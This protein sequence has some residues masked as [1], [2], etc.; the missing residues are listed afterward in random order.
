GATL[1]QYGVRRVCVAAPTG[2]PDGGALRWV[3]HR[4]RRR[5]LPYLAAPGG[6]SRT[7]RP[8]G[9]GGAERGGG[10]A[11]LRDP[12]GSARHAR[13][14]RR[15]RSHPRLRADVAGSA[16]AARLSCAPVGTRR[17][18]VPGP[19]LLS[20]TIGRDLRDP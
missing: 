16:R 9:R 4:P 13:D 8:R 18:R 6:G 3:S 7:I 19:T 14:G 15:P 1:G 5:L 17:G 12:A 10:R 11:G 20:A 2:A